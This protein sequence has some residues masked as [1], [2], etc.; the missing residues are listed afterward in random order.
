MYKIYG[1]APPLSFARL[2]ENAAQIHF[3]PNW[4][5]GLARCAGIGYNKKTRG[6]QGEIPRG[7]K[8]RTGKICFVQ[9]TIHG[10]AV[11][12]PFRAD[13]AGTLSRRMNNRNERIKRKANP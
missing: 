3:F 2:P 12:I 1:T 8:S 9:G 10:K 7:E 11:H 6:V 5:K 4:K 13:G